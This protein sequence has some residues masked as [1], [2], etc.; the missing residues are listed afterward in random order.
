MPFTDDYQLAMS[1]DLKSLEDWVISRE[2]CHLTDVAVAVI[3]RT[4]L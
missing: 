4:V 1:T 2:D 3:P